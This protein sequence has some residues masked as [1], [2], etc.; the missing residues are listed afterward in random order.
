MYIPDLS[1]SSE[2]G[3]DSAAG[4]PLNGATLYRV[5]ATGD[6]AQSAGRVDG[7]Q[8]FWSPDGVPAGLHAGGS[9]GALDLFLANADGSN[10]Q[11]YTALGN[12]GFVN[13]SPDGTHFLYHRRRRADV[14]RRAGA[15]AAAAGEE[16]EPV[17]PAL[18][19]ARGNCWR[20]TT[21]GRTGCWSNE[22]WP[23]LPPMAV[24]SVYSRCPVRPP[25]T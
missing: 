20:S 24:P 15:G 9:D 22:R 7:V 3:N 23:A 1:T 11:L 16:H 12:G 10:P 18:D 4:D 25:T 8:V 14:R 13:W 2:T 17:R 6:D 21:Q 5:P 19:L